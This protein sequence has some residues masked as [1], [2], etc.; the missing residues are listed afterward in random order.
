MLAEAGA[1]LIIVHHGIYWTKQDYLVRGTHGERIKFLIDNNISLYA[2]HLPL[3][4][5]LEVGNNSEMLRALGIKNFKKTNYVDYVADVDLTFDEIVKRVEEKIGPVKTWKFGGDVVKILHICSGGG[6]RL[7]YN[8]G[9][10]VTFLVGEFG[11]SAY[12]YAKEKK[13]NVIEAGH[14]NTEKFGVLA[15][16]K[17]INR[18]FDVETMFID[19]PTQ[20]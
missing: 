7:I 2:A 5:H 18:K 10:G 1:D 3:D 20:M 13:I 11:H 16:M 15:L 6:S 4:A 9:E 12:H 17:K 8:F 14:Y 19:S